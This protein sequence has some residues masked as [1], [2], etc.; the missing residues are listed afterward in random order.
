MNFTTY[1][2]LQKPLSTEKYNIGIHNT[3]ADIIDSA[4]NRLEQ[5]DTS[6]DNAIT[7]EIKRAIER[8]N[9]IDTKFSTIPKATDQQDGFLSSEDKR[10]LDKVA[11]NT[12]QAHKVWKTDEQGTPAWRDESASSIE[13]P[14]FDDNTGIYSTLNDAAAAAETASNAIK[15]NTNI[16]T[17]LSNMK[18]SFS[19]IVQGLKILAANVGTINGI[20][21]DIN[22]ESENTAASIRAVNQLNNN[23]NK[24]DNKISKIHIGLVSGTTNN[25]G[26]IPVV[27]VNNMTPVAAVPVIME[28]FCAAVLCHTG[29]YHAQIVH[30]N[31]AGTPIPFTTVT[32]LV[33]YASV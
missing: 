13:T 11:T 16:L 8:E 23:L 14:V 17:T 24:T 32:L 20:T 4:L 3:N 22:C 27:P 33:L 9:E 29:N 5:K 25:T 30:W 12:G 6:Q 10:K 31:D 2:N 18:K 28:T 19:A 15:S 26:H 21:S 7:N 1:H